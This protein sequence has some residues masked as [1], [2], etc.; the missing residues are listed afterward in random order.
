MVYS[1]SCFIK[2]YISPLVDVGKIKMA[3]PDKPK[4]KY[5]KYFA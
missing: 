5:Q 1:K 3:L 4:S 2:T